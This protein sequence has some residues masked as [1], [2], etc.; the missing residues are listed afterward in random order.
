VILCSKPCLST[1]RLCA[2]EPRPGAEPKVTGDRKGALRRVATNSGLG[3]REDG[4]SLCTAADPVIGAGSNKGLEE[5]ELF[6][7]EVVMLG[8]VPEAPLEDGIPV[9]ASFD[10]IIGERK[11]MCRCA[12]VLSV[13][14]VRFRCCRSE[15]APTADAADAP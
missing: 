8:R 12:L 15:A 13:S 14:F 9:L 2:E 4:G 10:L 11:G 7:T 3:L 1:S 6:I 5:E